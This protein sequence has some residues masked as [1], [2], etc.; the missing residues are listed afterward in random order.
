[1][2]KHKGKHKGKNK[3]RKTLAQRADRQELYQQTVQA[4]EADIDFFE[5]I[6]AQHRG[7]K[8]MSLRED[9]CGTGL[10]STVWCQSD[11]ARTALG[12]D[13]SKQT[14]D[15]G[16]ENNIEPAGQDVVD[17]VRMVCGDVRSNEY[18]A[19]DMTV[20][21]N[22]S[23]C[24]F[25]TRAALLEYFKVARKG[26]KDDGMFVVELYGGMEAIQPVEDERDYEGFTYVWEQEKYNPID[27]STLCHI[28]YLFP[29]G[30]KLKNAFTY[31]WRL[32]SIAEVRE[33]MEEAGFS[34]VRVYWEEVEDEE[35]SD[36]DTDVLGGSGEYVE[37]NEVENQ[38]SWLVYIA[39]F[40]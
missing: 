23:Y 39:A 12:I 30:S 21:M 40:A 36:D 26:V 11:P 35:D 38:E 14:L 13:L 1:M 4:P 2:G 17:R 29:D 20:A 6:F 10:F 37:V 7:R 27:H 15:W 28:H 22:F 5:K 16:R 19:V 31:N 24:V 9:F 18:S 33:L 8:A 3:S 32:W 25:Q 34:K